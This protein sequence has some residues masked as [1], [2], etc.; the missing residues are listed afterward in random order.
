M[1]WANEICCWT[2]RLN[3]GKQRRHP[4]R[5]KGDNNDG[6]VGVGVNR[7]NNRIESL[8]AIPPGPEGII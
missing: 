7:R 8:R 4:A 2:R 1:L 6:G 5:N 3:A